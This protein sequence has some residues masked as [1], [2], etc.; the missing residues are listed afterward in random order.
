MKTIDSLDYSGVTLYLST[1]LDGYAISDK[2]TRVPVKLS[3]SVKVAL[4]RSIGLTVVASVNASPDVSYNHTQI[5]PYHAVANDGSKEIYFR[6]SPI[7]DY[8]YGRMH[9]ATFD[10]FSR[11][12]IQKYV[13]LMDKAY[14]EGL[15]QMSYVDAEEIVSQSVKS[16]QDRVRER[17]NSICLASFCKNMIRVL[18]H[19]MSVAVK[20]RKRG[21]DAGN[22]GMCA[23]MKDV[24][25]YDDKQKAYVLRWLVAYRDRLRHVD[26][27][28]ATYNGADQCYW[29]Y[30][31]IPRRLISPEKWYGIRIKFLKRIIE[32][33]SEV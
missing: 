1:L 9:C 33:H 14:E 30:G 24:R 29:F 19:N 17:V 2:G 22:M 32:L 5:V 3:A 12:Q 20:L 28:D 4:I 15:A 23:V 18:E 31:D 13:R 21:H 10:H 25:M 27:G 8:A 26:A 11:A 6:M 7:N 16:L